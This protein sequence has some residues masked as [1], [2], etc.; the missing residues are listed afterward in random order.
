M[1][2][3]IAYWNEFWFKKADPLPL[4]I[5]R[6][7]LGLNILEVLLM[8]TVPNFFYFFG[9]KAICSEDVVATY[10]WFVPFIFDP[11]VAFNGSP[12][13]AVLLLLIML[14]AN[15]TM[16]LGL[17]T[18]LSMV[19]LFLGLLGLYNQ[20]VFVYNGGDEFRR[21]ML[22]F[23]CFA[24]AGTAFSL[25]SIISGLKQDWRIHGFAPKS[26]PVWALRWLQL[27]FSFIYWNVTKNKIDGPEWRDGTA[28]YYATHVQ[29]LQRVYIP[30][31]FE[32][33]IT[34]RL[35]TYGTIILEG[36]LSVCVWIR[37]L[38]Y[39]V[40]LAGLIFHAGIDA[41]MAL[42]GFETGFVSAYILFVRPRDLYKFAHWI[43]RCSRIFFGQPLVCYY[44]GNQFLSVKIAGII[45]RLDI[46]RTIEIKE[47]QDDLLNSL[48][49]LDCG[50]SLHTGYRAF[51][52]LC[53]KLPLL[54][55]FVP[56]NLLIQATGL[57]ARL[58]SLASGL[59]VRVIEFLSYGY[60]GMRF[61]DDDSLRQ[62]L[63]A[64][65]V[66]LLLF[67]GFFIA[68]IER[69]L[70][71]SETKTRAQGAALETERKVI[72]QHLLSLQNRP[73]TDAQ[74]ML[75]ELEAATVCHLARK[76]QLSELFFL[77]V[78]NNLTDKLP[79]YGKLYPTTLLHMA[80]LYL[81]AGLPARA[82]FCYANVKKF[83]HKW[84]GADKGK[85]ARD[86]NNLGVARYMSGITQVDEA[87]RQR[88]FKAAEENVLQALNFKLDPVERA[89]FLDNLALIRRER[90]FKDDYW[91]F[92][93]E[94][95][96][97][98]SKIPG[99]LVPP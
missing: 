51:A 22:M 81:D 86:L 82:V 84:L 75:W 57:S 67:F 45:R 88:E 2:S 73:R 80:D 18:R 91:W 3:P 20:N 28:V 6:V 15:L 19:V 79:D 46:F 12:I 44:N 94:S 21:L 14:F 8:H 97:L 35:L 34:I 52:K 68:S 36:A 61:L 33:D 60:H 37:P 41:S 25:D 5:F 54:T 17:F 30:Q 47:S 4:A 85:A 74:R 92:K 50:G 77:S 48:I 93:D 42:P 29:D 63:F 89:N 40:L 99:R 39:P 32:H 10:Y 69:P 26:E 11:F 96:R 87:A 49:A 78:F 59:F 7:L 70:L 90:G 98:T 16:I 31:L 83:D 55:L 24:P 9:R 66:A 72:D 23:L 64:G 38:C 95:R 65:L 43:R 58:F 13:W 1:K 27:Q 76:F 71:V 56:I 62:R 53:T